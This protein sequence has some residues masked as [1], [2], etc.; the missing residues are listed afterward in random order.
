MISMADTKYTEGIGR[1][2]EAIARVRLTPAT[3]TSF[4]I[5]E[6]SLADYFKTENLQRLVQEALNT[7]GVGNFE[8]SVHVRGGGNSAQAES[9]RLGISRALV[10]IDSEKRKELKKRGYLKRDPR[11]KERKKFGKKKARKSPQWSKR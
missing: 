1:R 6:K 2:K 3:K 8:I 9:I 4:K 10:D 5:N 7:E 11:V